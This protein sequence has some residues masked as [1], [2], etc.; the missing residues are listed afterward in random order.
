MRRVR[1][2]EMW[3]LLLCGLALALV[4]APVRAER[5]G[6][7]VMVQAQAGVVS[8]TVVD[9]RSAPVEAAR[10]IV[11]GTA[12][13]VS[14]DA[15]GRFRLTGL[16]GSE[17][18]L[19]ITRIGFRRWSGTA[20]VGGTI[21]VTMERV[22][23]NLS[24]VVVTGTAVPV[25]RRAVGNVVDRID[26]SALAEVAPIKNVSDLL[27]GR[28]SSVNVVGV[29][30]VVGAGPQ[31]AIRGRS[32]LSLTAEPLIYID[33]VRANNAVATGPSINSSEPNISRLGDLNPNE[34][35]SIEVI[36]GPAAATL[37]GTEASNGVI[38]IITKRGRANAGPSVETI[39]RGGANW[40]MNPEGRIPHN[41][42]RDGATVIEQDLLANERAAGRP[43]FRTGSVQGYDATIS[44][45]SGIVQ[46]F[47]AAGYSR[48]EGIEVRNAFTRKAGRANITI[49]PNQK[50]DISL[51]FGGTNARRDMSLD[52]GL[53]L[54]YATAFGNPATRNTPTRGFLNGPPEFWS[55]A[56][57]T[58]QDVDRYITGLTLNHR[59]FSWLRHRLVFG[60]DQSAEDNQVIS[61]LQPDSIRQFFSSA[62]DRDGRKIV[63]RRNETVN[64]LDYALTASTGLGQRIT[65]TTSV[66]AQ[67]YRRFTKLQYSE[68]QGFP[69]PGITTVSGAARTFGG[70]D[71][72]ENVTIGTYLQQVFAL[73]DRL[74]VT[75]AIRAD[76]NSAFGAAF[77]LVTYPKASLSWVIS[78]EPFW[79]IGFLESVKLRAAYGQSGLQPSAFAAIRTY[80]PTSSATGSAVSPL[81]VGNPDLGPERST[82]TEIGFEAGLLGGR[83]G[84]DFNYYRKDTRDMILTRLPAPSSGFFTQQFF[85]AGHVQNSGLEVQLRLSPIESRALKWDVDFNYAVNS[86]KVIDLDPNNPELTFIGAGLM[87][88]TEG[89]EIGVAYQ[90]KVVSA[91]FN[92]TTG[93]AENILCDPGPGGGAPVACASAPVVAFGRLLPKWEG[94]VSNSI[95]LWDRIVLFAHFDFRGGH[96]LRDETNWARCAVFRLC[97]IN[98]RP[99]DFDPIDIANNQL[100]LHGKYFS[101][102]DFLKLRELSVTFDVP[103]GWARSVRA[104]RISVNLAGRNLHTWTGYTGL[105]PESAASTAIQNYNYYEQTTTPQLASFA[106]TIRV[107]W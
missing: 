99:E 78:D 101:K 34:I 50:I 96:L 53:S 54:M 15:A 9:D 42:L 24:E 77:D 107:N 12:T 100:T 94:G 33:G 40:F 104:N 98:M 7:V 22:A 47:A 20:R 84:I 59:P 11:R 105:D 55:S 19:D 82:E 60:L 29:T 87:R 45:G 39:V 85:N 14:T 21:T 52:R 13:E 26:A 68:G 83:V 35:E 71:Y 95:R 57:E 79:K 67:Y 3:S 16:T 44:G 106:A 10:V 36:K 49:A 1:G 97:D 66:G 23:L 74:F 46:Y 93:L 6:G 27:R 31:L 91:D 75:G 5:G 92:P 73:N 37:Y 88:H 89:E 41:F 43:L 76:D 61:E 65:S 48:E 90:R 86:S 62:V 51:N 80:R 4:A 69:A 70:D 2:D 103:D 72:L 64:T 81:S 102:A 17:V 32:S 56:Y 63:N 8:G 30:G 25:E 28:S 58:F 18:T 38:Q